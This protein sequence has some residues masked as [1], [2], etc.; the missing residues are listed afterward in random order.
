M[1][2]PA[3]NDWKGWTLG[4]LA[5]IGISLTGFIGV[6]MVDAGKT[7]STQ[8][9]LLIEKVAATAAQLDRVAKELDRVVDK[10]DRLNERRR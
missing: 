6:Q 4:I 5:I 2:H 3:G 9:I 7:I 1:V 8:H 10:L